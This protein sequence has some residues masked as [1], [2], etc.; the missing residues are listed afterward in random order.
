M[1]SSSLLLLFGCFLAS[2]T[3]FSFGQEDVELLQPVYL[4]PEPP[5]P[6][7]PSFNPIYRYYPV[8]HLLAGEQQRSLQG[9][10]FK[11]FF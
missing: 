7:Y 4:L 11:T 5:V 10:H 6:Y 1:S 2:L 3:G 9:V 8:Q